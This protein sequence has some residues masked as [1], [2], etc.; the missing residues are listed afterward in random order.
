MIFRDRNPTSKRLQTA[1]FP[2]PT[3]SRSLTA[4]FLTLIVAIFSRQHADGERCNKPTA[5]LRSL[6]AH[7]LSE[8][9]S[10]S[11]VLASRIPHQLLRVPLPPI[12]LEKEGNFS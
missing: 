4:I 5:E 9:T 11:H 2:L 10:V 8:R 3:M 1:S 12:P 7:R 6:P